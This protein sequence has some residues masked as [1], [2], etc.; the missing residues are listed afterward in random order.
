MSE[1]AGNQEQTTDI[2]SIPSPESTNSFSRAKAKIAGFLKRAQKPQRQTEQQVVEQ[3]TC[4]LSSANM[5]DTPRTEF[6]R[7]TAE[8]ETVQQCRDHIA[9]TLKSHGRK[10]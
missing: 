8:P 9:R 1:S 7:T 6:F 5:N 10:G 3:K 4:I 2:P